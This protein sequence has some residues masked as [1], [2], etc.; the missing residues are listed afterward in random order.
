MI[1]LDSGYTAELD[2]FH[3]PELKDFRLAEV[4]FFSEKEAENFNPPDWFGKDV[5][6]NPDYLNS[7]LAEKGLPEY[8]API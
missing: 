2:I 4:E 1:S 6:N 7:S 5:S 3:N 8:H